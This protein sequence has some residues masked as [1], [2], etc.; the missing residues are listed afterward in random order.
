MAH[1]PPLPPVLPLLQ[2]FSLDLIHHRSVLSRNICIFKQKY[3]KVTSFGEILSGGCDSDAGKRG[4]ST[5]KLQKLLTI[6]T[7]QVET[8]KELC[9]DEVGD[10][11]WESGG[12]YTVCTLAPITEGSK[13]EFEN[14]PLLV[15]PS[16]TPRFICKRF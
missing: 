1:S 4:F 14:K 2:Q 13:K 16:R 9:L 8:C 15:W 7:L 12:S 6:E 3:F 10:E 5:L 11:V